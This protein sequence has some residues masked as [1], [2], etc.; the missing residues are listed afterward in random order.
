MWGIFEKI[1]SLI[2]ITE[3]IKEAAE[4]L[5]SLQNT[6]MARPALSAYE[7][8]VLDHEGTH[9][10]DNGIYQMMYSAVSL[11]EG[12]AIEAELALHKS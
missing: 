1:D 10:L 5:H 12:K 11:S 7:N 8:L 4:T 6:D 2:S 3:N 9:T